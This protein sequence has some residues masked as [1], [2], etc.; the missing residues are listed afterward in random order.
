LE[1][2]ME[3][4]RLMT[5]STRRAAW[6]ERLA[7]ILVAALEAVDPEVAVLNAMQRQGEQLI[8]EDQAYDLSQF[9]RVLLVGAGKAGAPMARAAAEIL[10]E[11][12]SGGVVIVKEGYAGTGAKTR[13]YEILEAGHPIPDERG[14]EATR[15]IKEILSSAQQDDLVICLISGGG[16][17]LMTSPAAGLGLEDLQALTSTLL[18]CGANINEINALR[19]HL[20]TIKGGGIARLAAPATL[21]T[22]ILSDVVGDPLDVIASGPTVP[23]T[24]TFE[25]AYQVLNHYGIASKV[26]EPIMRHLKR[27]CRGDLADTPKPG[28]PIFARVRNTVI[29]SNRKAAQ[30]AL[31]QAQREGFHSMLLTTYLQGEARQAG[32]MLASIAKQIAASDQPLPRPACIVAGGET[33]VTLRSGHTETDKHG[34]GG[35]NQELA[36]SAVSDLSGLA[37]IALVTLAT[38]GGDGPTDAAGAIVTGETL[39]RARQAGFD[40]NEFLSCND[41]YHFFEPLGDLL[42]PGP[43]QTNVNDLAFIFAF[44]LS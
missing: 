35:R 32:R 26:P 19:K 24:S 14:I 39:E 3:P 25:S 28:D 10:G 21:V 43:T 6:G 33:T 37:N 7:R 11:R 4:E 40:P 5:T 23:D 38:D 8:I 18:A 2:K 1:L 27:G 44:E 41:S 15:R 12:L 42:K 20:D 9:R 13:R 29:G 31:Q 34:L 22:L 30:A 17:A 16:S 36:L